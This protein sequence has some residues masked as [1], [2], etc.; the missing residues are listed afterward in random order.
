MDR[1]TTPRGRLKGL[2][3]DR[4]IHTKIL[5]AVLVAAA[6]AGMVG[7]IGIRALGTTN[8]A[9]EGIYEDNFSAFQD[10]AS[11]RRLFL[12]MRL[13]AANHALSSDRT[14]KDKY[15]AQVNEEQAQI[16]EAVSAYAARGLDVEEQAALERV[17]TALGD[18]ATIVE[19]QL[20]PAGEAND[21]EEWQRVRDEVALPAVNELFAGLEELIDSETA[22][23]RDAV[24]M[25]KDK[26]E[27]NRF[28]VVVLL[29]LGLALAMGIGVWVARSIV[30][31]VRRV[32]HVTDGLKDGDLTRTAG[33]DSRDEIGRMGEALDEAVSSLREMVQ[34]ID[35]SAGSLSAASE[36]LSSVT[37]QISAAGE[38]TSSQSDLVAAAAEQVSHNVQT[39]ATGSEEMGAS[40]REI[41]H[42]ANEA[43]RV[44]SDAVGVAAA[45]NETVS[46][47][48]ESSA[49]IGNVVKVITSIAEQT[50]LLALNATIEAARAGEAGKGFAVVANEVKE[51]A[52][53]TAR[54]TED[55][56]RRVE[57]IQSDTS[58]A[59][60]AI[61][62]ISAIIARINDFQ[63]TIASAVEEQ[64]ATTNE[65]NRNVAE[66]AT[67]STDI[68]ANITGV[69]TAAATTKEGVVEAQRAV[70]ELAQMSSQ[71][72][73]LVSRFTV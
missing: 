35:G 50:N 28:Q 59:V 40:I 9:T 57:A 48:G 30:S 3:S 64:T 14:T 26:Y 23:A 55:I 6:V 46:K 15:V 73:T 19:E 2:I 27:S 67:G 53:E 38:Q 51:L 42:N 44:A 22:D 29:L 31:G 49:E 7:I 39:V 16:H 13:D 66:A 5:A 8:K 70:D 1:F 47:L 4:G 69:A 52:Q 45:T 11:M 65:M 10:A 62:E 36:E 34:T 20:I 72:R 18:Y 56:S 63:V 21:V 71:L 58:N 12:N 17:R 37:G 54:A 32:Q 41:A 60:T 43:A 33:V 68:A 25:A 24:A 61:G